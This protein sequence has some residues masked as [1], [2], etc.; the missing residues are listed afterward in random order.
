LTRAGISSKAL[1]FSGVENKYKYDGKE[2]QAK[3]FSDGSGLEW[4]DYGTRVYDNQLGRWHVVDPLADK[5]NRWSVY[6]YA[7]DNP[8]RFIDPDGSEPEDPIANR[9]NAF[10]KAHHEVLQRMYDKSAKPNK[11]G[12]VVERANH[13]IKKGNGEYREW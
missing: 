3:E 13:F 8:L 6:N 1:S 7:F 12:E 10:A 4:T 2:L 5:M 11:S 9:L